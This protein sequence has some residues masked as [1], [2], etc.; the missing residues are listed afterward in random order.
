MQRAQISAR[1]HVL[2]TGASG[3]VG[4]AVVQLAKRCWAIVERAKLCDVAAIGADREI[5]R[6]DYV[7]FTFDECS[8][9]VVIDNV[10]EPP[11]A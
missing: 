7:D 9:I 4:A 3:G 11:S 1:Q 5:A 2:V 8:V 10:A 6:N